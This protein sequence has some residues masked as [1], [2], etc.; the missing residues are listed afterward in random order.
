MGFLGL[1]AQSGP[2]FAKTMKQRASK[3]ARPSPRECV[4]QL[5]CEF[6]L[7]IETGTNKKAFPYLGEKKLPSHNPAQWSDGCQHTNGF[8]TLW[9]KK[10]FL[11]LE[12]VESVHDLSVLQGARK[13]SRWMQHVL[14]KYL[15]N[16]KP[17]KKFTWAVPRLLMDF[18]I[19]DFGCWAAMYL[20]VNLKQRYCSLQF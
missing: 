1:D 19:R 4:K 14:L 8:L 15:I 20:L 2:I 11:F 10:L 17:R 3:A 6:D 9:S 12:K 7:G 5:G 13:F 16:G 18:G